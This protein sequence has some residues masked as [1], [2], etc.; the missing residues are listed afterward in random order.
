[1]WRGV[2]WITRV[3]FPCQNSDLSNYGAGHVNSVVY[4][5]YAEA[6]RVNMING[7]AGYRRGNTLEEKQLYLDFLTSQATGL[8]LRSIRTY[9]K[10]PLTYPDRV[11]VFH[12]I[13]KPP[14]PGLDNMVL[15]A[16]IVSENH[17]RVAAR[18]VEDLVIYDHVK[19]KNSIF[20]HNQIRDLTRLFR[21]QMLSREVADKE[22]DEWMD[23]LT[24]L[25]MKVQIKGGR[26]RDISLKDDPV[27]S[28]INDALR[29]TDE[30]EATDTVEPEFGREDLNEL[31]PYESPEHGVSNPAESKEP[32]SDAPKATGWFKKLFKWS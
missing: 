22:I 3:C 17:Y 5:K 6:S 16:L 11:S 7:L 13:V 18:V 9:F 20:K 27:E 8:V 21:R 26:L 29:A 24:D 25:E 28:A 10:F 1:M 14:E 4:N 15:E 12:K 31:E 19:G 30:L 32:V 23:R 2:I